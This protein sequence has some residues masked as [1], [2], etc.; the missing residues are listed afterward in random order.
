MSKCVYLASMDV[1]INH[2]VGVQNQE[3]FSKC[4]SDGY[5]SRN[6]GHKTKK[7]MRKIKLCPSKRN[8]IHGKLN[9]IEF[10]SKFCRICHLGRLSAI[11]IDV[12]SRSCHSCLLAV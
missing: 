12:L 10:G 7:K 3:F 4:I 1:K 9:T 5:A 8:G 11:I 2:T 6:M